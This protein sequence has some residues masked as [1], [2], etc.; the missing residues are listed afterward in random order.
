M[1]LISL[2]LVTTFLLT[3]PSVLLAV[4]VMLFM[5]VFEGFHPATWS[6][7]STLADNTRKRV[8]QYIEKERERR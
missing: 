4:L 2:F 3:K 8:W 7:Q 6:L 5:W 1:V